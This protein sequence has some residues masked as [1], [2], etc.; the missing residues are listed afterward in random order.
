MSYDLYFWPAGAAEDARRLGARLADEKAG[1]LAPDQRVLAFRADLLRRWP[2]LADMIHPWHDDL[3]WRKPGGRTDLADRYVVV[4]LPYN[5][6]A[7]SALPAVAGMYGLDTYDPQAEQLTPAR[8]RGSATQV[9]GWVSE[10]HVVQLLRQISFYIGYRYDDLDEA[11]LTGA[12]DDTDDETAD[13]WFEYPLAGTPP[14]DVRLAR[15]PGSAVVSVRVD[16]AFDLVL[17]TR[18]E[19]LLEML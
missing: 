14:L 8:D 17:A 18:V 5:W 15:S 19:T 7:T 16:G 11:A 3:G 1:G 2:E 13:G 10:D 6:A 12:L 4:T 9:A